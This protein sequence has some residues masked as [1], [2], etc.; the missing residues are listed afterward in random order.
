MAGALRRDHDHV[1]ALGRRD[2]AV[3]D[4][5]A[6]REEERRAGLEVRRDLVSNRARLRAV[7][8]EERDELRALHRLGDGA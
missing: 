3:V 1:V 5:E 4:V 7:G 2:A 8:D 6:V